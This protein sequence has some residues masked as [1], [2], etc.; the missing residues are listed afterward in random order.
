MRYLS[1]FF[2]L[3]FVPS[4]AAAQAK[5]TPRPLDPIAADT[6]AEALA[7]SEIVRSLVATLEASNVL[8][9]IVSSRVMPSG[10]GG[11]TRF[12]T[13]RGGYRYVRITIASELP[14]RTRSIILGHE[15]QHACEVANSA[16]TDT[17]S[18][19]ELFKQDGEQYG[20]FYE[21]RAAVSIER[22]VRLELSSRP[23]NE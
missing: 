10:I 8:V 21:T 15:L 18:I 22:S 3:L 14:P 4:F 23:R 17:E 2:L 19:R 16:A 6:F 1:A 20:D 11:M 5:L 13:S 7:G 9:H 12:V